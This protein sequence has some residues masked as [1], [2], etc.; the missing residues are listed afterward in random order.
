LRNQQSLYKLYWA[1]KGVNVAYRTDKEIGQQ[2][3]GLLGSRSQKDLA[4]AVGMDAT[5]L[6]KAIAGRRALSGIEL[7]LIANQVGVA[8]QDILS[9]TDAPA[10]ALR[11]DGD[12]EA[13]QQ[14]METCSTLIDGYLRLEALIR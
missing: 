5:A 14:A 6:N 4:D 12:D 3:L 2:I 11:A 10:F 1:T 9:E 7:V 13:V 8:P